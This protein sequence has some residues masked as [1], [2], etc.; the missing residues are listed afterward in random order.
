MKKSVYILAAVVSAL[1]LMVSCEKPGPDGPDGPNQGGEEVVPNFPEALTVALNAGESHTLS[2]EPNSDWSIELKYEA[3]SAGWFWIQDGN[4]QVYSLRGKADEKVEVVVFTSEQTDYDRVH[5]CTLEMTMGEETKVIATFTRAT[6][7]RHF[8]LSYCKTEEGD[9]V[10][11]ESESELMYE[12]NEPLSAG[13]VIPMEWI[14]RTMS[15]RRAILIEADFAWQLKS[16]PEWVDDLKIT[17]GAAG[18]QVEVEV[19]GDPA[20]YPLEDTSEEIVFCAADNMDA[21]YTYK[22][23][24]PGCG[25]VF[26]ISGF[27][28]ETQANQSGEIY[29]EMM[30]EGSWSPAELG[31]SGS[32]MGIKGAVVYAF[33]KDG[34]GWTADGS[35]TEW[36]TVTLAEW[37]EGGAVLQDRELNI[38][39]SANESDVLR[40]AMVFAMP[41]SVAPAD[42][43]AVFSA[44]AVADEYKDYVVTHL[45]QFAE[46]KGLVAVVDPVWFADDGSS[47]EFMEESALNG[48]YGTKEAYRLTYTSEYTGPNSNLRSSF[49]IA[50]W[51]AYDRNGTQLDAA[52][53]WISVMTVESELADNAFRIIMDPAKDTFTDP[54]HTGYIVLNDA[55]GAKVTLECVFEKPES[56]GDTGGSV[57]FAD[58]ENVDGAVLKYVNSTNL[59]DMNAAYKELGLNFDEDLA[60]GYDVSI[61]TYNSASPKNVTLNVPEYSYIMTMPWGVEWLTYTEDTDGAQKQVTIT[62]ED[63][64]DDSYA[65]F[66]LC[67]KSYNIHTKIYCIPAF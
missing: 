57:S 50:S 1:M 45:S 49:V 52:T 9:Y 22:V 54:K 12:Y 41:A 46:E 66:Q 64:G 59:T 31:V 23:S 16:K 42:A 24:I 67:D 4:S 7:D 34:E 15:Y 35:K 48:T 61:L 6:V 29:K 38:K 33:V 25:D 11:S 19:E 17:T 3:A 32:V 2:L 36:I 44:G 30:G 65:Q 51:T 8:E 40:E 58:H 60:M 56:G 55:S 28:A 37:E 18:V 13:G 14:E 5:E 62:M 27:S 63:P 43:A 39:V 26:S 53:S 47:L 20:K 21:V 10:Y